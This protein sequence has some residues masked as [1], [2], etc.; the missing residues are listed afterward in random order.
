MKGLTRPIVCLVTDRRR[1]APAARTV[2]EEIAALEHCVDE[3]VEAGVD[4]VQ[5]RERDLDGRRLAACLKDAVRRTRGSA[6]RVIVN[7]RADLAAAA[8]ADGVHVRADGPPVERVRSLG[9]HWIIG[10]SVHIGDPLPLSAPL[11]YLLFGPVFETRSK[12][13]ANATGLAA[14]HAV[15]AEAGLPVLA[16]GGITPPRAAECC[17]AGA[18]GVAGIGVFLPRGHAPDALGVGRAVV[19]LRAAMQAP[20]SDDGKRLQNGERGTG[21]LC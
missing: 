9:P 21:N 14:L 5:I 18:W 15:A 12:L 11:D 1:L 19:E 13:G 10:R 20:P 17:R 6:T 2:D 3:A 7:D 16:I 8:E 4:V